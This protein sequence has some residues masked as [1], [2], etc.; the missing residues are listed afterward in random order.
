MPFAAL[1]IIDDA[2]EFVVLGTAMVA[3]QLR[4]V[5]AGGAA[6]AVVF[7]TRV[8]PALLASLDQLRGEGMSIDVARTATDVADFIHPDERVLLMP[9]RIVIAPARLDDLVEAAVPHVLCVQDHPDQAHLELID[10][11]ARWTGLAMIDGALIRRTAAMVGDWDLGSTLLRRALQEGAARTVLSPADARDDLALVAT[12]ADA[13]AVGRRLIARTA[14]ELEGWGASWITGPLAMLMAHGA[15]DAG[16]EGRWLAL[17]SLIVGGVATVAALAGWIVASL[18]LLLVTLI[19]DLAGA[20]VVRAGC[21]ADPFAMWRRPARAAASSVVLLAMGA[22]LMLRDAQWGCAVLALVMI[23]AT[24]LS[25]QLLR[26]DAPARLW[27]SDPA[28]NAVIGLAGFAIGLPTL[29]LAGATVHAV[30]SLLWAHRKIL[31][32]LARP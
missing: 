13:A 23:G 14:H 28:G 11:T 7:V 3:A 18:V 15:G 4:R 31:R 27:R 30:A 22:T 20:I 19:L 12:D 32:G 25:T 9:A 21:G 24:A 16:I 5:R 6:H 17:A 8:T 26:D 1:L 2:H 10:A 29:A